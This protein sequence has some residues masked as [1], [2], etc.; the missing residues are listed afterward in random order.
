MLLSISSSGQM[1]GLWEVKEVRVGEEIMTPVA[2]WFLFTDE[3]QSY[4]GNGGIQNSKGTYKFDATK[5]EFLFINPSGIVDE[6]G[7]FTV[8]FDLP[9]MIWTRIE[10]GEK[11]EVFLL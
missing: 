5:S 4:S 11:V 9:E 7:P 10:N 3:M 8:R 2:K 1:S 6:F